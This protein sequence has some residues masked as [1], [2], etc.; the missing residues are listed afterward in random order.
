[1]SPRSL[2]FF[3]IDILQIIHTEEAFGRFVPSEMLDIDNATQRVE[4]EREAMCGG[5]AYSDH[6][7]DDEP[8]ARAVKL[9][10]VGRLLIHGFPTIHPETSS[11]LILCCRLGLTW[12]GIVAAALEVTE[13]R[14][15]KHTLYIRYRNYVA[16]LQRA[17]DRRRR[18]VYQ[19]AFHDHP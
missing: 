5:F 9:T 8:Q 11:F 16:V 7:V 14:V 19:P 18:D 15:R 13:F 10:R 4:L 2:F 6:S 1:M 12:P 17:L 3:Q